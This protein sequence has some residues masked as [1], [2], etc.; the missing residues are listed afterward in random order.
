MLV[1][2]PGECR[3]GGPLSLSKRFLEEI[4]IPVF[5]DSP[6]KRALTKSLDKV[7]RNQMF[8]MPDGTPVVHSSMSIISKE[9]SSF[10]AVDPKAMIEAL[11]DLYDS[12][13]EWTYQTSESGTDKL[14]KLCVNAFIAT[15]PDWIANNL[16][17]EA[18]G[19]GFT[20][21]V[22]IISGKDKYKW[23]SLPPPPDEKLHIKLRHDLKKIGSLVGEFEWGTGSYAY[24]DKW[25]NSIPGKT[26]ALKDSR[27]RGNLSRAHIAVLKAAMCIHVARSDDLVI[28]V[29]DLEYA[30]RMIEES[31]NTASE[32]L[33]GH[34]R[35]RTAVD[36]DKVLRQLKVN[37]KIHFKDLLMIN[38]HD[39]NK[40]ELTEVLVT[41]EGMG[42]CKMEQTV[43]S[44]GGMKIGWIEHIPYAE[45]VRG[46]GGKRRERKVGI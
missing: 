11:T 18:I 21:R 35:S 44:F 37:E 20:T 41:I 40:P 19:G 34:G 1:A 2:L 30:I 9:F 4:G 17:E 5:A 26:K 39:T 7:R 14:Y 29:Q 23:I 15:T 32:A 31:L 25:Y 27:L 24:Y 13:D 46:G 10:L 42:R 3:K 36:V 28:E 38:Y 8:K 33:S 12:H 16:P 6:T 45:N 43:D 22:M